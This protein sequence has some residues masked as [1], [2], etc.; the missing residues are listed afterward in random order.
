MPQRDI[1]MK[2][3]RKEGIE[4]TAQDFQEFLF[5]YVASCQLDTTRI[6]NQPPILSVQEYAL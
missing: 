1:T 4:R 3:G 5:V 2:E 6:N